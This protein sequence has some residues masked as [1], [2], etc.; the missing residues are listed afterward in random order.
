MNGD[1]VSI[2]IGRPIANTQ[3]YLLDAH[4]QPVPVGV[5]GEVYV[6]GDNLA[7]GYHNRPDLTVEK[8]IPNP[9]GDDPKARLYKTG[10]L[11]RYLPDGNIEF[12]GRKD[13]QV[14]IRGL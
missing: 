7:R 1:L 10:D 6:G 8:F 13:Y 12:I 11:A 4:L 9:F 3:I 2:P 14:K 5:T